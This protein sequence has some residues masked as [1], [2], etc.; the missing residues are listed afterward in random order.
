MLW[1]ALLDGQPLM[2]YQ[3]CSFGLMMNLKALM[4]ERGPDPMGTILA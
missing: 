1:R 2:P 4:G 3:G